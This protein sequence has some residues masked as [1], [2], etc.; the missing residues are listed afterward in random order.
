MEELKKSVYQ[1]LRWSEKYTK[2]DM[3]YLTKGSFWITFSQFFL[4][5]SSLILAIAFAHFVPKEIYGEYKFI[6]SLGG[7]LST[8][9]LSGVATAVLQ[10]VAKGY[11]SSL[12]QGFWFNLRW[13]WI[14]SLAG[15]IL[16]IYYFLNKNNTLGF[17]LL[18]ISSLSPIWYSTNLFSSFLSAKKD[19]KRNSLYFDLYSNLFPFLCLLVTMFFFKSSLVLIL[20]YFLSNTLIGIFF[21]LYVIRI[22]NPKEG[23]DPGLEKYSK[24]LS[25]MNILSGVANNLDQVLVFHYLGAVNLAIYNFAIAIPNRTKGVM[26]GLNILM[27]PKYTERPENDIKKGINKKIFR[28]FLFFLV[29]ITVYI[30]LAPYIFK[31]LFPKY[32]EAV[33]YS[34]LFS[35]SLFGLAFW[36]V[37][38]YLSA[39]K[40]IKEQYISTVISNIVQILTV[41]IGVY[42]WG[43]IGV[44][45]AR[46]IARISNGLVNY[47]LLNYKD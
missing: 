36:P 11:E 8:L 46:V 14:F 27:F 2:T 43:L 16:A 42:F 32:I 34:R 37:Y 41:F 19:F 39:K 20:V 33:N 28:L 23:R 13:S 24:H 18:I 31:I 17:S 47:L 4:S 1:T 29:I 35:L 45:I 15:L 7:I 40:K 44:V 3:V 6:I 12:K 25:F 10:S 22:Y 26:N 5:I 38:T 9:M 30:I 21:Y